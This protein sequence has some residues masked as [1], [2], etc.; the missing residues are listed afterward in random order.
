[1]KLLITGC[2]GFIGFNYCLKRLSKK[3][4]N[5]KIIGIDNLNNYY[6]TKIK[7]DRL[8]L[9]KKHKNFQ[10]YKINI[11]NK[12]K[13]EKIFK[14]NKIDIIIHLAAQA[15]VGYS[16]INP[17]QYL[18]SNTNG[19]FNIL[20]AAKNYKIRKILY[21]S[22]S[23]VYGDSKKFPLKENMYI[24][25]LNFY[26]LTKKNNE[27]MAEIYGN[28]YG[29]KSIGLRFFTV[30][31]EWGRPD[32]VI[33]KMINSIYKKTNFYLNNRGNHYRDFTYINDVVKIIDKLLRKNFKKKHFVVNICS[34]KPLKITILLNLAKK[35][36][37][38]LKYRLRGF[39]K[40]DILKTHGCNKLVKKVT[41]INNFTKFEVGFLKTL[42]WYKKY[43]K[44]Y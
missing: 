13:L 31:G 40:V 3:D 19:F 36:N 14:K 5:L 30:F 16:L 1:M 17:E 22:S 21:A 10:F 8:N 2:A 24:K 6:S 20:E 32:M 38:K 41:G 11:D 27:E 44:I 37:L 7:K 33:L 4:K 23:S 34:N 28:F 29:V 18:K 15:G 35:F 43:N 9:L 42:N 39:Q 26:G 25:P 12:I